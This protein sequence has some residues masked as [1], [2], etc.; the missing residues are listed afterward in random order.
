MAT[1]TFSQL[2]TD[3]QA[4][5]YQFKVDTS[6]PSKSDSPQDAKLMQS[7][8][9]FHKVKFDKVIQLFQMAGI[10]PDAA[11]PQSF[12]DSTKFPTTGKTGILYFDETNGAIYYWNG[13]KYVSMDSLLL[14]S[15][16]PIYI[17][18]STD[19][20]AVARDS[21][22]VDTTVA[23]AQVDTIN[24]FVVVNS[25]AYTVTINGTA[26]TYTSGSSATAADITKGV[27]AA[28]NGDSNVAVTAV[29]NSGVS[30]VLTAK[31][32][33]TAFT[34]SINGNMTDATTTA[35]KLKP[36]TITLP[37]TPAEND[38]VGFL[39]LKGT[40]DKNN[41]TV[42]RNGQTIMGL[43]QDMV[44]N[45]KNISFSLRFTNNDWRVV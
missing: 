5:N 18:T 35:N 14:K 13:T 44:V 31:V 20:T 43:A 41:L 17:I 23:I 21:F 10:S 32:A 30:V 42:A 33:G 25:T 1:E 37:A 26:Y 12:T 9:H 3:I 34:S 38:I 6:D 19:T 4:P 28:I 2:I 39:D 16:K 27:A 22:S 24:N 15:V 40:F 29:D 8:H 45:T 7:M 11:T 36:V